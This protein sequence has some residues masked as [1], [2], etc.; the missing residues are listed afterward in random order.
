[1]SD[2]E[3]LSLLSRF[4]LGVF[5]DDGIYSAEVLEGLGVEDIDAFHAAATAAAEQST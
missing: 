2:Q 3:L 4:F 1:M 5:Q